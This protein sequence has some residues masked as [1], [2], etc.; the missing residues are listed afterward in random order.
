V[1]PQPGAQ[2]VTGV[3]GSVSRE[4]SSGGSGTPTT[5]V[6]VLEETWRW[7]QLLRERGPLAGPRYHTWYLS[8][9]LPR[10]VVVSR[11]YLHLTLL[12]LPPPHL[13]C[14]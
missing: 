3:G 11:F 2:G 8:P 13:L 4:V 9:Y 5:P 10:I 14:V 6:A 7:Q 1:G 12:L